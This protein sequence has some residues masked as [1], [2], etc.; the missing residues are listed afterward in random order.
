MILKSNLDYNLLHFAKSSQVTRSKSSQITRSNSKLMRKEDKG[1][2]KASQ[3][4]TD[5]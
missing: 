5:Q 3:R 2:K 4:F 1:E